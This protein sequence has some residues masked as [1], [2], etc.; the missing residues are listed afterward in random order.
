M[1][2][3]VMARTCW[4]WVVV[5]LLCFNVFVCECSGLNYGEALSKCLLFLEA[6]RSGRLPSG[7]R[8]TWRDHSGLT[9]GLLQGV[10]LVGGYYDAGDHV[11]FG[12]PMA[13][14]VTMLAWSVMEYGNQIAAAGQLGY[15]MEAIKWGTDYFMKA[16]SE[17]EVL[18]GEVGDGDTDHY[19]W[20]RP[21]DMTTSRQAYKVDAAN[22]GSD[23][24]GETAAAMAS[25]SIVFSKSNPAYSNLLLQ[26]AKQLFAFADKYRGKYD[27][28]ISIVGKYYSSVSGY[29]DEL[30]WA[31][32]WMYQATGDEY[33]LT[34]IADNAESLGGTGWAMT[35][36]SWDV[37][38]AGLQVLAAKV[39]MQGQGGKYSSILQ[40]YQS[41][42]EFFLCACLKKNPLG[43]NVDITPGGLLYIREW[44]N[45][46]YV[47]SASFLLTVYSD[48]L[49]SAEKKLMCP[50]AELQ[51]SELLNFAQSQVDYI[52]GLNP[53]A[54]SYLVGFGKTYPEQVHHRGASIIS[55]KENPSFLGCTQGYD[56]WYNRK[57]T[58][59]N[60]IVGALVGGPDKNDN[61]E[62]E[63]GNYMQ[64]EACTYNI[65]P[66]LGVLAKLN[67][68]PS[69]GN[70]LVSFQ[71]GQL[72]YKLPSSTPDPNS[73]LYPLGAFFYPLD[74]SMYLQ[75][76]F[77]YPLEISVLDV[78]FYPL[79][80]DLY[81]LGTF[82]YPLDISM[83]LPDAFIYPL[84][85][86]DLDAVFYP[87]D[88]D[89]YPLG[90]FFYPLD[91]SMYLP[92][93][94]FYRLGI[95][96]LDAI[97]YPLDADL[98]P[99]GAFFY[100]LDISVY[101]PDAFFYPLDILVLDAVFYP[102]DIDMYPLGAFF[103]PLDINV[104]PPNAMIYPL[105]I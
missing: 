78:V 87:L 104:Y 7:Q 9:D 89:L 72:S 93:A 57:E 70:H 58:N 48:Y 38:Y 68:F 85:I 54:T 86:L 51:P 31:A 14:T 2:S 29:G 16:H 20:Q 26:H 42:A 67:G 66:L 40:K 53:R 8:V 34:Y 103:Y 50:S 33:Y 102:M 74:I 99:M 21:E 90:A 62:D 56:T 75:D 18:W 4:F 17:P 13:F 28:S 97:F 47:S 91:I 88:A 69:Q 79:D 5:A 37:K 92:D 22:P 49:T 65:A 76:A 84:D 43:S 45:M 35:E 95:S 71:P 1:L 24:A 83:Y 41:K 80:T 11:K 46:Q 60:V 101:L 32:S 6:Q 39:L 12:L 36:F 105:D 30:L 96:A 61:F 55:Y 52:L 100:P 98:Y 63:R 15:T 73:D 81:P 3:G 19:C 59:P 64:T 27:K 94:F 10:D 77:F 44:N 23:L 82:F 25:A